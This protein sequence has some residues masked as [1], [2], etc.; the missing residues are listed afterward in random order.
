[1]SV[2]DIA[3]KKNSASPVPQL[4]LE[5]AAATRMLEAEDILDYSGH[6]SCRIPGRDDAFMI[7]IGSTSRQELGPADILIVDYDCNVLEGEGKPPSETV[8][9]CRRIS[10]TGAS[11]EPSFRFEPGQCSTFTSRAA[12]RRCSSASTQTQC[13]AH[14]CGVARCT[15]SR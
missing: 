11:P 10:T 13:A 14:R 3:S 15:A 6:I 4:A 5:L 8:I 9:P 7:Q 12:S 1:M 2:T